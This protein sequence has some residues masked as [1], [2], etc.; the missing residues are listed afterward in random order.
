MKHSRM[1]LSRS[2]VFMLIVSIVMLIGGC[3]KSDDNSLKVKDI[4]GNEY[5]VIQIGDQFWMKPNLRVTKY[6]NGDNIPNVTAG[7]DN[8]G[9]LLSGAYCYYENDD[10]DAEK[11]GALYNAYAVNDSR[12]VCP[13]GFRVPDTDDW[14]EL[15]DFLEGDSIAGLELKESGN[16]NW[17]SPNTGATN[18]TG[19][20]ALPAGARRQ[21]GGFDFKG[22]VG[23]WWT[24]TESDV[25]PG[26]QIYRDMYN[27]FKSV[28][29]GTDDKAWGKSIRCIKE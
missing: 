12:G 18:S 28:G 7:G 13:T 23:Q 5:D 15:M 11:F 17:N 20:T 14:Q 22:L 3:K 19:F 10:S 24:S 2:L 8:W 21:D 29:I 25:F 4:D 16:I 1:V 26:K 9:D 6:K 27:S